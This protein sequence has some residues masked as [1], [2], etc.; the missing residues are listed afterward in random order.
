MSNKITR[1]Q[2]I[3]AL[4]DSDKVCLTA[5]DIAPIIGTNPQTIRDTARQRPDLLK[6]EFFVTGNRV[7]IPRIPFLQY[8]GINVDNFTKTENTNTEIC[9]RNIAPA[10]NGSLTNEEL[11]SLI[12]QQIDQLK[13]EIN[14]RLDN[15][16]KQSQDLNLVLQSAQNFINALS[17]FHADN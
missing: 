10:L 7:K 17:G 9:N 13:S 4:I 11:L 3:Q 6:F 1:Q 8:I 12:T 16:E 2:A 5:E 14:Q 15:I